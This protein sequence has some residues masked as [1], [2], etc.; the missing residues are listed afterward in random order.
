MTNGMETSTSPERGF[1]ETEYHF[2]DDVMEAGEARLRRA[3]ELLHP[4]AGA[5]FL[6]LGSGVGWAAHLAVEGG[7]E[8]AVGLDFAWRALQLGAQHIPGVERVQADGCHL[9]LRDRSF[10]RVLSFGSL[11][12]FPDVDVALRELAR[13]LHPLG[14]AVV[15]VPN[16]YVRTEQPQELRLR[17]GAWRDR[18][19]QA[20]LVITAT[21]A[22]HGPAIMRNHKPVRVA[23][24]AAAKVL[25]YVPRL[26]YQF[27]FRIEH[28]T[29]S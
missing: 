20:G 15:V 12:H 28:R 29:P 13:V 23:I 14:K 18:F 4:L 2:A 24:R 10:E 19:E 25:A 5:S 22:D 26:P 3:I 7:A 11:E 8:P 16:F 17:Y 1:Y 21:R 27:I 6:D 9:P